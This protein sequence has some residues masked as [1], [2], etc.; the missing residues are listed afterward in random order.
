MML[1]VQI[2]NPFAKKWQAVVLNEVRPERIIELK[3]LRADR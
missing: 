3:T 2:M 1:Q